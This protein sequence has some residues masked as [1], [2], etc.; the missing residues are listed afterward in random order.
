MPNYKELYFKS[1]AALADAV[2]TLDKLREQLC[3]CMV[4]CE[5]AVIADD[6]EKT[7]KQGLDFLPPDA[8]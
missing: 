5:E 8:L 1:Q 4:Q 2:E 3:S 6:E 7:P